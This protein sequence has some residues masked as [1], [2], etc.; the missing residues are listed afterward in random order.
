MA[1]IARNVR[2]YPVNFLNITLFPGQEINLELYFPESI[3]STDQDLQILI[4]DGDVV[5]NDG[6]NDL[7]PDEALSL[8]VAVR[9]IN[10]QSGDVILDPD[11]FDDTG[12]TNKFY[13]EAD[14]LKLAGIQENADAT[15]ALNVEAAGAVMETDVSTVA[16]NFVIDDDSMNSA[17]D[18]VVPTAESVVTYVLTQIAAAITGSN[19]YK[20]GYNAGT[21]SPDLEAPLAGAI[22]LGHVYDVTAPGTCTPAGGGSHELETGDTLRAKVDDPSI[23][24]DWVVV[25]SNLTSASIKTRYESNA[26]TNAFT[27]AEQA[28]LAGI[29]PNATEDQTDLEIKTA[30]ENNADTNAF[31]D[32]EKSKLLGIEPNATADQTDGEIKTAY[33]NNPDTNAFTD[34]EQTKV[35]WLS[36][37]QAVDLDQIESD[38]ATNNAKVSADGSV[39]THS[40]ITD[41]G[42]GAIITGLER[43]KLNGIED[44]AEVNEVFGTEYLETENLAI[45][46]NGSNIYNVNIIHT[47]PAA[48]PTGNYLIEF[49]TDWLVDNANGIIDIGFDS[50][51]PALLPLTDAFIMG[52]HNNTD[53][54]NLR[55]VFV[56]PHTTGQDTTFLAKQ[57]KSAGAGTVNVRNRKV[58][59][60]RIS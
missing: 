2:G 55:Q 40:D 23:A 16:M 51:A 29:E 26:D 42:S 35:G 21:N 32:S 53:W 41:A 14:S 11:S 25:Q 3:I 19:N 31:T 38:T 54:Y 5:I 39:T 1:L 57:R 36:V 18:T 9:S 58:K 44:G 48:A 4:D 60:W 49:N 59:Q 28:K 8:V 17:T 52:V 34:A 27:D 7:L 47:I 45:A 24:A 43:T 50:G 30:Y 15:D 13:P 37:T 10:G 33:E 22:K 12:T 20:G 46:T 6:E 56:L